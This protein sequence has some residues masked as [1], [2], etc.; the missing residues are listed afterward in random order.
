MYK[1]TF[2]LSMFSYCITDFKVTHYLLVHSVFFLITV[3][4]TS[5]TY[6]VTL[7]NNT[8][9]LLIL[10]RSNLYFQTSTERFS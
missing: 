2:K 9:S 3:K 5:L 6:K 7:F 8:V 1:F 10:K 4:K